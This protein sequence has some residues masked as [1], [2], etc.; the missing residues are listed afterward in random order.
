LGQRQTIFRF[1]LVFQ[2]REHIGVSARTPV[3]VGRDRVEQ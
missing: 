1:R 2:Q 3:I